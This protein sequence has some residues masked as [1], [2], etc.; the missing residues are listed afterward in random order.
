[1]GGKVGDIVKAAVIGAAIATGVGIVFAPGLI[2][3][4]GGTL[5]YFGTTFAIQAVLGAVGSAL[6]KKPEQFTSAGELQGRQVMSKQPIVSRKVVYGEV[7]TSGPIVFLETTNNNQNL[8]VAVAFTGHEI[9]SVDAVF[10]NDQVVKT[11]LSDATEVS[12]NSGTVPD[13]S[14]KA[15]LT[16]HFGTDSQVADAN[17]VSRTSLTSNHRLRG[18]SYIYAFLTYDQDVFANGLPNISAVIK[19]K[20]V[21]DPRTEA[22]A[23]SNNAALCVR[24]YLSNSTYGLGASIDEIDDASFIAAANI[25]DEDVN[26]LGGGTE[27]RYTM[28]GVVDTA[29][30]PAEIL[31]DM[32]TSCGGTIY[33]SNGKWHIKVGAYV[34]PTVTLDENDLRGPIKIQTR[35]SGQDQFNAVKGIFVSPENNWQPTDYP[36]LTSEQFEFE[37]GGDRKYIDLT[38]PFTTS[39]STAQR[40]AKQV[41]Y[42]NREQL[43]L[44]MPCKLTA[45]QFEVGDTVQITNSRLG[46]NAKPFEVV[47]WSFSPEPQGDDGITLG[48]D[49][50]LKET[51]SDVYAWDSVVDEA[52]F[53]FNN[54]NLPSAFSVTAPGVSVSDELRINNQEAISVL[55]V[56]VASSDTFVTGFEVQARKLGDAQYTNLGQATGNLFELV[57]V[58]DGVTYDVR[59]RSVNSFGVR[60]A[61]TNTTH[62]VVGKTA[63]P[64]D[65][66][67]FTGNVV[68]GQLVLTWT[69]VSDLDLSHYRLRYSTLTFGATYQEAINLSDKISRPGNLAIVP[70][71]TG[72]YFIK[73]IDKLGLASINPTTIV[74]TTNIAGIE[75]L[76]LVDTLTEGPEFDGTFDDTVELD[77]ENQLIL[78]TSINFD[79]GTGNFDDG[80]GL[81]DGGSGTVDL[82]GFYYF[83]NGSD[84][85]AVYTS[86]LTASITST[87]QDYVNTFDD[88][89]G[90]FDSREGDFDGDVNAFDNTDVELQVR[91]TDDNPGGSP[92]W[93]SWRPF[94]VGD[95][96][97]RAFEFRLR[98]TT[99][100]TQATP[101]VTGASVTIDMPDRVVSET[102]VASG[103]GAKVIA[104]SPAFKATPAIGISASNLETG[105]FYEITSKSATGF[106]ITFKNSGG[107]AVNRTF[108][109]VAKGYG[110]IET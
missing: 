46:F 37:D 3:A 4:A 19:G 50:V 82:E 31:N 64:S 39:V 57:N 95:Y 38:L 76:N 43:S 15:K 70:A 48:V 99:A 11:S 97:A 2:A 1:M 84:L 27:K 87:R 49:L 21:Y 42:R 58:E 83:A 72:T 22:V 77:A 5:A 104:F 51:N 98:L 89:T 79:S 90:L 53:T 29:K 86:R 14:A 81:F 52:E 41:L 69:P 13:Y 106:T 34:T 55:V 24:D 18:I 9:E 68:G 100:D 91:T 101:V 28:N 44:T 40:L 105:D 60:S 8:H 94:V 110:R 67:N 96:T 92:T 107:S 65:V 63:P 56:N 62:Q 36:E 59:A 74:V 47:S 17:L 73:A 16:A 103:A 78:D 93:S 75:N 80:N 6:Q 35:N 45:F 30:S 66:T 102:D 32:L 61:F 108:D 7:K 71:R 20:K 54:T 25:C 12:A 33:Y 23:Y 26:V 85:G 109:Y 10:L 88:A